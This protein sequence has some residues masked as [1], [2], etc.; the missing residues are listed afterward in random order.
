[1]LVLSFILIKEEI[2]KNFKNSDIVLKPFGL[3]N[4][5]TPR[6]KQLD[7]KEKLIYKKKTHSLLHLDNLLV[8]KLL[9]SKLLRKLNG[10]LVR[11]KLN[12][13]LMKRKK[14]NR[15]LMRRNL[16]G[17]L[18]GELL[19]LHNLLHLHL[20]ILL[21]SKLLGKLNGELMSKLLVRKLFVR[22]LLVR[23]LLGKLLLR[24]KLIGKLM[25]IMLVT[26]LLVRKLNVRNMLKKKLV[27]L[28]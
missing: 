19:H 9:V 27:V 14:L 23:K 11:K 22:K 8:S 7:I 2:K 18:N 1:M 26:K 24:K 21:V 13:E 17:N 3:T 6:L 20:D 15:E 4:L 16:L 10:E 12:R 25:R 5:L 28:K